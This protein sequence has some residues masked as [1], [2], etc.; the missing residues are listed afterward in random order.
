[1]HER[2]TLHAQTV[3]SGAR[4]IMLSANELQGALTTQLDH[5]P[6]EV[7]EAVSSIQEQAA[8]ALNRYAAGLV[9]NA[10][11]P[12]VPISLHALEQS[13]ASS[14][15]AAP[16]R[17]E[18]NLLTLADNLVRRLSHLPSWGAPSPATGALHESPSHQ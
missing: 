2:L 17:R 6:V 9:G 16:A 13:F 3:L 8:A 4:A 14:L 18:L 11:Q 15:S 5:L 1:E 10:C 12:P 7:R